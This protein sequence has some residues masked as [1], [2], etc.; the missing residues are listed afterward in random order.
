MNVATESDPILRNILLTQKF[1][2]N[3]SPS[4]ISHFHFAAEFPDRSNRSN[5][6]IRAIRPEYIK[7][8]SKEQPHNITATFVRHC[9]AIQN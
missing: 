8:E 6:R 5:I 9:F 7:S 2:E 4:T 1:K 3:H